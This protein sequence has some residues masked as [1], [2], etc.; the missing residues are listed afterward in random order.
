M[1]PSQVTLE[2]GSV[3]FREGEAA[4]S[5]FLIV[6]G[7]VEVSRAGPG[8]AVG[9]G[10]LSKGDV[11]GEAGLIRGGVHAVTAVATSTVTV[12]EMDRDMLRARIATDP[13]IAL[14]VMGRLARRVATLSERVAGGEEP[15][16]GARIRLPGP[17][18]LGGGLAGWW[19]R[20]LGRRRAR[21]HA[22]EGGASPLTLVVAALPNDEGDAQRGRLMACFEALPGITARSLSRAVEVSGDEGPLAALAQASRQAR[23]MLEREGADLVVWGLVDPPA[24]LVELHMVGP[25]ASED[26]RPGLPNALTWLALPIDFDDAWAPLVRAVA[27]SA[28]EP[29]VES[30]ANLL[31]AL[32]PGAIEEARPLGLDP[33]MGVF[34]PAE[35]AA[36]LSCFGNAAAALGHLNRDP[37]WSDL[38]VEAYGAAIGVLPRD[39]DLEWALLHRAIGLVLQEVGERTDSIEALAQAADAY[40]TAL[41]A[42][43]RQDSPRDW[44]GLHYR[45]GLVLYKR[46]LLDGGVEAFKEPLQCLQSALQVFTR[47]EYPLRW[48]DIMNTISQVLQVYGDQTRSVA[49]LERAADACRQALEVRTFEAAPLPWAAIQN[50]LGSAL[51]L[52]AKHAQKRS[53]LESA[54]ESFRAALGT[55]RMMGADRAAG[56]AESNLKRVEEMLRK[57]G[58]PRPLVDPVWAERPAT[59][60]AAGEW[61]ETAA[62]KGA[63]RRAAKGR[64]DTNPEDE[65]P[66]S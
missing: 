61:S 24:G 66:D 25:H 17:G 63:R 23:Q 5:A 59:V 42:L 12:Q 43:H 41:E 19:H 4:P 49:V 45:M 52:L 48:A 3:L 6:A 50:N 31:A 30:H 26:E 27:L 35:R 10:V 65:A 2:A 37:G 64:D 38:A 13:E 62:L 60:T 39:A 54:A 8:G 16:T 9:L 34:G 1:R 22:A 44:A 15:A 40:R 53:P 32:L 29:R 7:T 55:Y 46:A 18:R 36:I 47:T 51:F 58:G 28:M 11:V 56:V 21:R 20:L 33:P 14:R 57:T